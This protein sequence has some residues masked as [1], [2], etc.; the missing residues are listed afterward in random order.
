VFEYRK[1]IESAPYP[2]NYIEQKERNV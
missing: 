1:L 2:E